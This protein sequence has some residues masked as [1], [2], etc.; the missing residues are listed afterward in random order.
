MRQLE[1][2][3]VASGDA[4]DLYLDGLKKAG[5]DVAA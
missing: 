5:L 3:K 1:Q 2:P 4:K